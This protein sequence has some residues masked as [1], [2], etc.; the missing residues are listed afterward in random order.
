MKIKILLLLALLSNMV[1]TQ[2]QIVI[3]EK[4]SEWVYHYTNLNVCGPIVATYAS[5]TL[6]AGKTAMVIAQTLYDVCQEPQEPA[7]DSIKGIGN[8]L[9]IEDSLVM[10][11]HNVKYDTLYDFGAKV[12][13]KWMYRYSTNDTLNA[14]VL[15]KGID[16]ELGVFL[17]LEF[18]H[19]F[20][21]TRRD[22][23]YEQLLGGTNYIIPWDVEA[24]QL[25]GQEG[26]PLRCFTD[27]KLSYVSSWW[28]ARN[29]PCKY[30]SK[31]V[32][33]DQV[34][35]NN[36]FTIYPNPS[37]GV[38]RIETQKPEKMEVYTVLGELVYSSDHVFETRHLSS[39]LYVVK[40]WRKDGLVEVHR[41]VVE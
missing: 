19:S 17:D 38:I 11:W 5:D 23:V 20:Y 39:Q 16:S 9:V 25:D 41:V 1:S 15:G 27:S 21:P 13:D 29:L 10:Y 18:S 6:L 4:G 12:G 8:V 34:A 24:S 3:P 37:K 31:R 33:V 26:G 28:E 40:L 30:L 14:L 2:A 32:D 36:L 7:V 35:V 22:T